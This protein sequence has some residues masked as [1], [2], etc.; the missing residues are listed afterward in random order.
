MGRLS[1]RDFGP[2]HRIYA[3]IYFTA[4]PAGYVKRMRRHKFRFLWNF[5]QVQAVSRSIR[6]VDGDSDSG[7]NDLTNQFKDGRVDF[8][9]R[10]NPSSNNK[11]PSV[12]RLL[13]T[14]SAATTI[15]EDSEINI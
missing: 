3:G 8:Q 2:F 5:Q 10:P 12:R 4:S 11:R 1:R 9:L 7:S 15:A 14:S 6:S 13:S